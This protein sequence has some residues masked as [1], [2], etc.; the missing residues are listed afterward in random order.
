MPHCFLVKVEPGQFI[1]NYC[2]VELSCG[3]QFISFDV[4]QLSVLLIGISTFITAEAIFVFKLRLPLNII[5]A[6]IAELHLLLNRIADEGHDKD[7]VEVVESDKLLVDLI[8]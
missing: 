5:L 8:F 2:K 1:V 7:I 4:T 3:I 6:L